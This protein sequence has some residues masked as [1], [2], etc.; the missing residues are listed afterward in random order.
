MSEPVRCKVKVKEL[1]TGEPFCSLLEIRKDNLQAITASMRESGFDIGEPITVWHGVVVDGHTRLEAAKLAKIAEVPCIY[2][3]FADED[4]AIA[5]AIHRQRD[6]RNLTAADL[7][8]LVETLDRRRSRVEQAAIATE[9]RIN[10]AQGCALNESPTPEPARSSAKTAEIIGV[11]PRQV[12]K[13]RTIQDK[14]TPE[15]KAAVAA[16]EKSIN[17]AYNETVRPFIEAPK[18]KPEPAPKPE[19]SGN[20]GELEALKARI[21]ELE[22]ENEDLKDRI[23]EVS[24]LLM[25]TQEELDAARRTLDAE[26]I[27]V[28]FDK[29]IKR[30]QEQARVVQSR[31]NGLM[32]ENS[33]LKGRL[34]SSLRKIEKLQKEAVSLAS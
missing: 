31:N 1:Q 20:P 15:V 30:A 25:D 3:D 12:E 2:R 17:A 23:A 5:Y 27:L 32:N 10:S 18:P 28:K 29:E 6:R 33:D 24:G 14:A 4:E 9:A 16:G 11:S 19:P 13:I 21:A 7:L 26:N 8:R 22:A 34:K